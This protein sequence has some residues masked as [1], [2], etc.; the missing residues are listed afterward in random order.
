M[1]KYTSVFAVAYLLL[2]LSLAAT[3]LKGETGSD[4]AA[5]FAA[6]LLAAWRFTKNHDR[7]PTLDEKK[8]FAWWSLLSLLAIKFLEIVVVIVLASFLLRNETNTFKD[9][10]FASKPIAS[11]FI[12]AGGVLL[13]SAISYMLIRWSFAWC[14]KLLGKTKHAA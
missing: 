1:K 4:I 8:S 12:F 5:V 9:P 2:A 10:F 7:E 14:A 13:S 3:D 6:S 11:L